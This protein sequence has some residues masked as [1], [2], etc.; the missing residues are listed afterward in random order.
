MPVANSYTHFPSSAV[1]TV[2][3]MS[4]T[5]KD[6]LVC[7]DDIHSSAHPPQIMFPPIP[8]AAPADLTTPPHRAAHSP[9][10]SICAHYGDNVSRPSDTVHAPPSAPIMAHEQPAVT[11][12]IVHTPSY[13]CCRLPRLSACLSVRLPEPILQPV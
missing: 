4:T 7:R 12:A 9:G 13:Q 6:T 10:P 1:P 11:P 5:D 2:L 8:S 3:T